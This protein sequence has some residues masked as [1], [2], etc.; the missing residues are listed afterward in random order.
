MR[1]RTGNLVAGIILA[2][3]SGVVLAQQSQQLRISAIIPPR[4]CQFPDPC[5]AVPPGTTSNV[6]VADGNVHYVGS[7]PKVERKGD[8]LVVN[9]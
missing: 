7:T 1:I 3:F 9:F 6:T 4:P 5:E 2:L 8:L